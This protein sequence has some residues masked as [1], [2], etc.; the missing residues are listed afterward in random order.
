M[1]CRWCDRTFLRGGP[2]KSFARLK[3]HVEEFHR[4][5]ITEFLAEGTEHLPPDFGFMRV[6]PGERS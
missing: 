4:D 3:E 2:E 6:L 1:K 5:K